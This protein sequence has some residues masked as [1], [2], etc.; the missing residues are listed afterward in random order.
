MTP[1]EAIELC[2]KKGAQVVDL[3]F[4]DLMGKWHH[5]SIPVRELT[6]TVFEEGFGFDGSSLRAWQP[7][8]MSDLLA[9]PDARTAVMDPFLDAPT[10]ILICDILEPITRENYSRD[11]RFIARKAET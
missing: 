11:P 8:H 1:K 2:K 7:I 9:I 3:R 5:F 6:E 10:M 4:S